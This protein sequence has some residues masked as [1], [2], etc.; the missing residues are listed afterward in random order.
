[1]DFSPDGKMLASGS[2][3]GSLIIWDLSTCQPLHKLN[4]HGNKVYA[5]KFSSDQKLLASGS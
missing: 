2:K 3:N 5:V 4:S 1:M